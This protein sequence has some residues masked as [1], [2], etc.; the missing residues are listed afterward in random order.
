MKVKTLIFS[1]FV[2]LA[3]IPL[4]LFGVNNILSYHNQMT[5]LLENDLG[6][7]TN[8]QEQ[9]IENFLQERSKNANVIAD[10]FS[11]GTTLNQNKDITEEQK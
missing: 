1:L 7:I 4:L 6:I 10:V 2:S 5:T 11:V 3:I 9:V 8:M